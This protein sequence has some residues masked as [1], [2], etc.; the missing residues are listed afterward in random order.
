MTTELAQ[1]IT[2]ET[3]V[4]SRTRV[5]A[6]MGV[7]A[8]NK[9]RADEVVGFCRSLNYSDGT[10]IVDV[11]PVYEQV[12]KMFGTQGDWG[13]DLKITEA[14]RT[15]ISNAM[16]S[17]L[18][19]LV[20]GDPGCNVRV[21]AWVYR[22]GKPTR[23]EVKSEGLRSLPEEFTAIVPTGVV[24][25]RYGREVWVR[26]DLVASE[27]DGVLF[28]A[29]SVLLSGEEGESI[30]GFGDIPDYIHSLDGIH[31][32]LKNFL[33][34]APDVLSVNAAVFEGWWSNRFSKAGQDEFTVDIG[35]VDN[36][37]CRMEIVF[38]RVAG[39]RSW[40]LFFK[41]SGELHPVEDYIPGL[42]LAVKPH[43][44]EAEW[45]HLISMFT[46]S[47]DI[48]SSIHYKH[49]FE[50][51]L[52]R[53]PEDYLQSVI[54][55]PEAMGRCFNAEVAD[56]IGSLRRDSRSWIPGVYHAGQEADLEF[57][58]ES[59]CSSVYLM[60]PLYLTRAAREMGCP[61]VYLVATLKRDEDGVEKCWFPTVLSVDMAF[62]NMRNLRRAIRNSIGAAA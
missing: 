52:E 11:S 58:G 21:L 39:L 54:A 26:F 60:A 4:R 10:R 1:H 56:T 50:D 24:S 35:E 33:G 40:S 22:G 8:P 27:Q 9:A 29:R 3:S 14:I 2:G 53:Y 62:S 20:A 15:R 28:R 48:W 12:R 36:D 47:F 51:H 44:A 30:V 5:L 17:E 7:Y 23:V 45:K 38:S 16:S 37:G 34:H 42:D 25:A 6:A 13:F 49:V 57:E 59:I 41:R 55:D 43:E 19:K 32:G 61:T 46:A 18:R 31:L